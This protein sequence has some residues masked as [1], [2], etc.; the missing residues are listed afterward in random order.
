MYNVLQQQQKKNLSSLKHFLRK[1]LKMRNYSN[2]LIGRICDRKNNK[3]ILS[4]NSQIFI[5]LNIC[6]K[7]RKDVEKRKNRILHILILVLF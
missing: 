2:L 1:K 4:S 3:I 5:Q 7:K 6:G